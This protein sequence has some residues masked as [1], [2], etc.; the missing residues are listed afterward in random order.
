[1]PRRVQALL[2]DVRRAATLIGQF[3]DGKELTDYDADVML[4]SA[5]ERQFMIIGEA[6]AQIGQVEPD[7]LTNV[8][9]ARRIVAFRNILVHG[10]AAIRNDVVWSVVQS[11]LNRLRAEVSRLLDEA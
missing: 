10:Y 11:D 2:E 7:L 8:T 6:L 4:R 9:D 3:T 1:M 5:V